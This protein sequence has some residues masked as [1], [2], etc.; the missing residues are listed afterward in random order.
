VV[1]VVRL[2]AVVAVAV[3]VRQEQVPPEEQEP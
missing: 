3:V 1:L 2:E